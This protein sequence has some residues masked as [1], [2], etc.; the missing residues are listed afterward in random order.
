[1]KT[2]TEPVGGWT[3]RRASS[4]ETKEHRTQMQLT[5]GLYIKTAV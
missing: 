5:E 3:R 4:D 2:I 1:M